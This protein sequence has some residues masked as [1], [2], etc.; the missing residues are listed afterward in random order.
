MSSRTELPRT[1]LLPGDCAPSRRTWPGARSAVAKRC[2]RAKGTREWNS[3]TRQSEYVRM[4]MGWLRR[5]L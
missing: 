2:F 5:N 3:P 1:K 4:C